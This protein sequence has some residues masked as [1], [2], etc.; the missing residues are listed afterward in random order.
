M[1]SIKRFVSILS[2][3]CLV[4]SLASCFKTGVSTIKKNASYDLGCDQDKIVITDIGG[5]RYGADGCGKRTTYYCRGGSC[6][7]D[8]ELNKAKSE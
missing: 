4:V 1:T 7:K 6:I 5:D 3:L 2:L 8:S